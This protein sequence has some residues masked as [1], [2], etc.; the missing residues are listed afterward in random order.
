MWTPDMQ[1]HPPPKWEKLPSVTWTRVRRIIFYA[2]AALA[3]A[4]AAMVLS[5]ILEVWR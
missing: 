2:C 4:D 1:E 5:E 3:G